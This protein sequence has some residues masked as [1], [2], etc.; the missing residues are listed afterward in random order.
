MFRLGRIVS[1]PVSSKFGLAQAE[2][3]PECHRQLELIV[4]P[5]EGRLSIR[6]LDWA[7]RKLVDKS[8]K[9]MTR[10]RPGTFDLNQQADK[11]PRCESDK[12][13][14]DKLRSVKLLHLHTR[15]KQLLVRRR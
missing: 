7:Y 6:T 8:D 10:Q 13:I 9:P 3:S 14:I 11:S 12:A 15:T 5:S 1:Q 4:N 2:L